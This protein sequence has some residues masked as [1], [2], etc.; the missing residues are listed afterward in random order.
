MR[1]PEFVFQIVAKWGEMPKSDLEDLK[2]DA[3]E[4]YTKIK[5][6]IYDPV[7]K[8]LLPDKKLENLSLKE[9]AVYYS[10]M[11][12]VRLGLALLFIIITPIVQN[13][14]NPDTKDEEIEED[15]P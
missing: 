6:G 11:W 2:H 12:T 5:L 7:N 1:I 14:L 4:D 9:K 15:N 8:S 3:L 10:E 13:W